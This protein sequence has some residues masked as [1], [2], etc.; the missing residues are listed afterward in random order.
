MTDDIHTHDEPAVQMD[1]IKE[2]LDSIQ[3]EQKK[4][5]KMLTAILV[6]LIILTSVIVIYLLYKMTLGS[7]IGKLIGL[8][9]GIFNA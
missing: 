8:V 7:I 4:Q 1:C 3:T 9:T 6:F 5:R 2:Q